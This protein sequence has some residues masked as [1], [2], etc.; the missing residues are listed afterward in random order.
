MGDAHPTR[1][2]GEEDGGGGHVLRVVWSKSKGG[3]DVDGERRA[4]VGECAEEP[5][6]RSPDAHGRIIPAPQ[7]QQKP[8]G[9]APPT[10]FLG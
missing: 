10:S 6:D 5:G 8:L 9:G 1:F 3:G 7:R 2:A 4:D